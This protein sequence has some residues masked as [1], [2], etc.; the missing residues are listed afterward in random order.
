LS[1]NSASPK[2]TARTVAAREYSI[3]YVLWE[4]CHL[5]D[6][7]MCFLVIY[8]ILFHNPKISWELHKFKAIDL[9]LRR[10]V[11]Q[12]SLVKCWFAWSENWSMTRCAW[13]A[14][15]FR[16]SEARL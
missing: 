14:S 7:R 4:C 9:S 6:D 11:E 12:F 2:S 8:E 1:V 16:S 3:K 15:F 5:L 10:N 13:P